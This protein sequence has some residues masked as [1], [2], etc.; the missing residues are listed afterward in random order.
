MDE[1]GSTPTRSKPSSRAGRHLVPLHDPDLPE[2]ERAHP[3]RGAA[4][5]DRRARPWSRPGRPR[6]R[7]VRARPLRGRAA[8]VAPLARGRRA[9]DVHV[10]VLQDGRARAARRVVRRARAMRAAY[11][12]RA[13]STYISPPLLP[14]AIVHEVNERGQFEPNLDRIRGIL[15]AQRDAMLGALERELGR[16]TWSRPEAATSSGSISATGST[17]ASCSR[18]RPRR[19]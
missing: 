1:E 5:T 10:L 14:Q 7:P 19:A 8:V 9:R 18:A 16:A 15:R 4:A 3:R 13:V 12:D 17:R 6:G 11:D 2:P